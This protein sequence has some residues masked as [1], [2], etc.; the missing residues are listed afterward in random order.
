[1]S[2]LLATRLPIAQGTETSSDTYNRLVRVLEINLGEF[3]PDNTRQISATDRD[4]LF[5]NPG[6]IIWETSVGVLQVYTGEYW[7][8]IST[9]ANP[10]GYQANAS[11]GEVSVK[12]NGDLTINLGSS[13]TGWEIERYY[14]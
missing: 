5:F 7:V 3:D 6:T 12:T 2:K 13:K 9:P 4:V 10:Q 11:V 14:S 1:V 8:D